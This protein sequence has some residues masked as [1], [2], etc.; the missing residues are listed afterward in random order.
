MQLLADLALI[1]LILYITGLFDYVG[2][3][4]CTGLGC[5][6]KEKCHRHTAA[7]KPTQLYFSKAPKERT[8]DCANF[9]SNDGKEK[10]DS[11]PIDEAI[12][13]SRQ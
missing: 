7:A 6:D 5:D 13:R 1:I 12:Y 11:P 3:T 8:D 2:F 4:K 9:V 10:G